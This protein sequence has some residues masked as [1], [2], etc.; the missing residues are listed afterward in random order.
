MSDS[1]KPF[2]RSTHVA[3]LVTAVGILPLLFVGAGVTSKDAGMVFPDW[4]TSDGHFL[5]PPGWL[6]DPAKLFEHG[7]RWIGF[8]V[9]MSTIW[10]AIGMWRTGGYVRAI[11]IASCLAVGI[12]GIA[13]GLRVTQVSTLLALLHGI[14]GQICFC[15][16]ALG[17]LLTSRFWSA[18]PK[19]IS[20]RG[21]RVLR[22]LCIGCTFALLVQL[23]L[24][25]ALR[26]FVSDYWLVAH[27]L[28]V[29]PVLFSTGWAIM[30]VTGCSPVLPIPA[31]IATVAGILLVLQ[32]VL[33]GFAWLVTLAGGSWP[34]VMV[35]L[36]PTM[37][38]WVGALILASF[39]LLTFTIF[40]T[41]SP[42]SNRRVELETGAA[43][44]AWLTSSN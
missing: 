36:I 14:W 18:N 44:N 2:H 5:N 7:H 33:G 40:K 21:G 22:G 42:I 31:R 11:G 26:H 10:A 1:P 37:H 9:G 13:G 17:A 39:V 35:W 19:P 34:S 15:I 8:I 29:M 24:G 43:S 12:Q 38:V 41:V 32:L 27:V 30:W 3:A 6:S 4:P 23:S 20:M 25:A 16:A 28:W